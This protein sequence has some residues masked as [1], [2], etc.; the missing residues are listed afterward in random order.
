MYI[1]IYIYIYVYV[2][3]VYIYIYIYTYAYVYN[4]HYNAS[5]LTQVFFRSGESFGKV[6]RSL[7]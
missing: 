5:C 3:V 6:W 1:Y 7:T 2:Y 4:T